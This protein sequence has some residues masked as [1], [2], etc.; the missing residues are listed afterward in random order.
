VAP[1]RGVA[2]GERSCAEA[3]LIQAAE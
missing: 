1:W 2:G 3:G